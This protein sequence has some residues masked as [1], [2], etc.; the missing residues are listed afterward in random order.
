MGATLLPG[1]GGYPSP[2]EGCG[3]ACRLPACGCPLEAGG[4]SPPPARVQPRPR[5]M[6]PQRELPA[7]FSSTGD[8]R[9][10]AQGG[11]GHRGRW[12]RVTLLLHGP[13]PAHNVILAFF[14]LETGQVLAFILKTSYLKNQRQGSFFCCDTERQ[15]RSKQQQ[16]LLPRTGIPVGAG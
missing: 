2:G 11:S 6:R 14:P 7:C 8:T 9:P 16:G 15:L 4:R 5:Q 12:G 13:S 3:D 1:A 10:S